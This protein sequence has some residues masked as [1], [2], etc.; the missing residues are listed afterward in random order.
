[1]HGAGKVWSV[2]GASVGRVLVF[3]FCLRLAERLVPEL[4]IRRCPRYWERYRVASP[5]CDFGEG[6]RYKPHLCPIVVGLLSN[7]FCRSGCFG[8]PRFLCPDGMMAFLASS[9]VYD[10]PCAFLCVHHRREGR[11]PR[12]LSWVCVRGVRSFRS[13]TVGCSTLHLGILKYHSWNLLG[14]VRR[15]RSWETAGCVIYSSFFLH[16]RP[17]L[18]VPWWWWWWWEEYTLAWR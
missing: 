11:V 7:Q 5:S 18:F 6:Q 9:P 12:A 15:G 3:V 14:W 8:V 13:A 4:S 17:L 2:F 16:I 1:V 10:T